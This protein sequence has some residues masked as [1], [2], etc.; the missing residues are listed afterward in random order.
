MH[1]LNNTPVTIPP[2]IQLWFI[3][4]YSKT[5]KPTLKQFYKNLPV[6]LMSLPSSAAAQCRLSP[7]PYP[8]DLIQSGTSLW[9]WHKVP[10]LRPWCLPGC[11]CDYKRLEGGL[12]LQGR[13]RNGP[14]YLSMKHYVTQHDTRPFVCKGK[15]F[16]VTIRQERTR[17][18]SMWFYTHSW[19]RGLWHRVAVECVCG[20]LWVCVCVRECI[21]LVFTNLI[22]IDTIHL[23]RS[24]KVLPGL[25]SCSSPF[26]LKALTGCWS[27]SSTKG[28]SQSVCVQGEWYFTCPGN[29]FNMKFVP[30]S[31]F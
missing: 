9:W 6:V 10:F 30:N 8:W 5:E 29:I 25:F 22:P 12:R 17:L 31:R 13:L 20:T 3:F 16:S 2:L 11:C 21:E 27:H 19:E 15:H 7:P 28:V 26:L 23:V 4:L 18:L 14:H 24:E 1:G